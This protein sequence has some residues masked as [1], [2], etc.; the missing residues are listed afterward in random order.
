MSWEA[1]WRLPWVGLRAGRVTEALTP[2]AASMGELGL[3]VERDEPGS[4]S[5]WLTLPPNP[6][7][8]EESVIELSFY[9]LSGEGIVL[10]LEGEWA[11]N[12]AIW[13]TAF[14]LVDAIAE[15]LGAQL[16]EL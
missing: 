11:D 15:Q 9:D 1:T 2:L 14:E 8:G 16:L 4:V 7:T 5:A 3:R 6:E 13:D 10:S 12:E